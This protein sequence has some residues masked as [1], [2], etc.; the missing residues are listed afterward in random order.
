MLKRNSSEA[1][2]NVLPCHAKLHNRVAEDCRALL[3]MNVPVVGF[4]AKTIVA[5]PKQ[6]EGFVWKETSK[7]GIDSRYA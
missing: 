3:N 5:E 2:Q 1:S 7:D 6:K 4:D